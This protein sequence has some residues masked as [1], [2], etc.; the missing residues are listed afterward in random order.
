[1]YKPK[2]EDMQG[3]QVDNERHPL[4]MARE[5]GG[6]EN[7][8]LG[9]VFFP[10]F[11][12]KISTT[13]PERPERLLYTRDQLLEEGLLDHPAIREYNPLVASWRSIERVHV[14]APSLDAWVTEAHRVSAGGAIA[15]AE[16]VMSGEVKRAFAL[17]RGIMR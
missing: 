3:N 10:A 7:V 1:M 14:G 17:V 11:D 6:N 4:M 9:L 12:W 5:T 16:A 13:H 15:A 8:P 2:T